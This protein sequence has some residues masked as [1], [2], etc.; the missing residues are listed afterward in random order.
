MA[1]V[2]SVPL[3]V[4]DCQ[5]CKRHVDHVTTWLEEYNLKWGGNLGS[6][7]PSYFRLIRNIA[8]R[9]P[10]HEWGGDLLCVIHGAAG[11]GVGKLTK[12]CREGCS[13]VLDGS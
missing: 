7:V 5:T 9:T 1:G 6:Q 10:L 8:T 3:C 2:P 4:I 12:E 13:G 11:V